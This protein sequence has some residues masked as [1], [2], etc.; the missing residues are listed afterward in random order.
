ML[1][2]DLKPGSGTWAS[3]YLW[4]PKGGAPP[5]PNLPQF[6]GFVPSEWPSW[7]FFH[8]IFFITQN[9]SWLFSWL[10]FILVHFFS[11][12][13]SKLTYFP[14]GFYSCWF[15]FL[16]TFF[17]P[18]NHSFLLFRLTFSYFKITARDTSISVNGRVAGSCIEGC[19]WVM[20][21]MS[22]ARTM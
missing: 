2:I 15:L 10:T 18:Q 1:F 9:Y 20:Q 5:S 11:T 16:F 14:N 13:K 3:P 21:W 19:R 4:V 12:P 17:L 7:L 8:L 6:C 22:G